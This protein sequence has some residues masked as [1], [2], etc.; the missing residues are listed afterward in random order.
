MA[1]QQK[2]RHLRLTH[3]LFLR[4]YSSWHTHVVDLSNDD[5]AGL[6]FEIPQCS[7]E[8]ILYKKA[9]HLTGLFY[10]QYIECKGFMYGGPGQI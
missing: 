5:F 3:R 1:G 6:G 10:P 8:A 4:K 7:P 2:R 9:Q